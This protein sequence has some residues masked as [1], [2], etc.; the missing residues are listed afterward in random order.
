MK[1]HLFNWDGTLLEDLKE[2]EKRFGITT[3]VPDQRDAAGAEAFELDGPPEKVAAF[4]KHYDLQ[5]DVRRERSRLAL[6]RNPPK[7]LDRGD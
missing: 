2:D 5:L 7:P 6:V 1:L 4:L 3:R